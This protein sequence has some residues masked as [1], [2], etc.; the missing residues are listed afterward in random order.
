MTVSTFSDMLSQLRRI[1]WQKKLS[2]FLHFTTCFPGIYIV[3]WRKTDSI[4][5]F[6]STL[7]RCYIFFDSKLT[8]SAFFNVL[9]HC[10]VLRDRKRAQYL[11]FPTCFPV[12]KCCVTENWLGSHVFQHASISWSVPWQQSDSVST[13]RRQT[14]NWIIFYTNKQLYHRQESL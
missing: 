13:L 9:P 6:S 8:V 7:L 1:P 10:E 12:V 4:S 3:L 11:H 2:K 14:T 5:T